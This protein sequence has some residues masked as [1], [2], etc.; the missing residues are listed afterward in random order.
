MA[1]RHFDGASIS[2]ILF[3][4]TAGFIREDP[5]HYIASNSFSSIV[6]QVVQQEQTCSG[7]PL[8]PNTS[9]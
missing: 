6:F 8:G 3:Q 9:S 7:V 2:A 1:G 4:K 5:S